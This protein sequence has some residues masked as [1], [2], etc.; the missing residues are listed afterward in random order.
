MERTE[1]LKVKLS[2]PE[3]ARLKAYA[4]SRGWN[5]SQAVRDYI[6]SLPETKENA[7]YGD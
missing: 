1:L 7:T 3:M 5:M 4:L 6:Y 2:S